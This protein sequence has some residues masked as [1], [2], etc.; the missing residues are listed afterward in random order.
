MPPRGPFL[1]ILQNV[2]MWPQVAKYIHIL[3]CQYGRQPEE[4]SYSNK[5]KETEKRKKKHQRLLLAF[6]PF[7]KKERRFEN[8]IVPTSCRQMSLSLNNYLWAVLPSRLSLKGWGEG[9]QCRCDY[10]LNI[11]VCFWGRVSVWRGW[12]NVI[13]IFL[14]HLKGCF[15][16]VLCGN[17]WGYFLLF[18]QTCGG[19]GAKSCLKNIVVGGAAGMGKGR[20]CHLGVGAGWMDMMGTG[21]ATTAAVGKVIIPSCCSLASFSSFNAGH[22]PVPPHP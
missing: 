10:K 7:H 21:A 19:G 15:D 22:W 11:C 18:I 17:S 2:L 20:G 9:F 4:Y 8:Q 16:T 13:F 12:A 5:G 3:Y 14:V 1:K 6:S